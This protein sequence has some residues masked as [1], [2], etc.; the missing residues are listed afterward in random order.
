MIIFIASL[1]KVQ[2]DRE[3][4]AK[5]TLTVPLS[6]REQVLNLSMLTETAL[7]VSVEE[8]LNKEVENG[9]SDNLC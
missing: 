3:G 5:I 1:H 9:K 6:D 2:I 7:K 4:E 8:E